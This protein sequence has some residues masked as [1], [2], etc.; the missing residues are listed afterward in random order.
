M[1]RVVVI[2][3][4]SGGI[5][6]AACKAFV[7]EGDRVYGLCRKPF[8]LAG[9]EF[10]ACDVTDRGSV[11]SAIAAVIERESRIDVLVSNAGFGIAGSV[12]FTCDADM[13]R[14]FDV[15]VFGTVRV[16]SEVLAFMRE[17]GSGCILI[18]GSLAA[19]LPIPFQAFYSMSKSALNALT[20]ALRNEVRPYS[21]RVSALMPGDIKTGF[22]A[23]RTKSSEGAEAYPSMDRAISTMEKDEQNGMSPERIGRKLLKMSK[24]KHPRP[25]YTSGAKYHLFAFLCRILPNRLVCRI[26][27]L[28]YS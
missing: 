1:N 7:D 6:L 14:Q 3:G 16:I 18:T 13:L 19:I 4:A 22:T 28:L 17:Q 9:A 21:I 12:E 5:G 15:N 10:V 26:I 20:M 27:G 8:E 23:A 2:T 11:R 24:K 25:L